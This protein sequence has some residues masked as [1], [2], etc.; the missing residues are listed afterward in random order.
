[1]QI[2]FI[3]KM[4][5]LNKKKDGECTRLRLYKKHEN[6]K[7]RNENEILI[8]LLILLR[9]EIYLLRNENENYLLKNKKEHL[10]NYLSITFF[11]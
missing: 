8:Y 9:K 5:E 7:L 3:L 11:L 2:F 1:M 10:Y 4:K 6:K